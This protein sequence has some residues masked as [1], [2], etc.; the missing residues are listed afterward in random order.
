MTLT[1]ELTPA[2]TASIKILKIVGEQGKHG[3]TDDVQ[4]GVKTRRNDVLSLDI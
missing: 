4:Y 3:V 2:L 1:T